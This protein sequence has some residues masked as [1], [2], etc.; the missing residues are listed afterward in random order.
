MSNI[1]I[2][3]TAFVAGFSFCLV[4]GGAI[5]LWAFSDERCD[6]SPA[7]GVPSRSAVS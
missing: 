2:A 7:G 4:L 3:V 6:Q 5:V 1:A